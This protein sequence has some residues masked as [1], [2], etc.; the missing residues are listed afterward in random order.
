M[1]SGI[2]TVCKRMLW[3]GLKCTMVCAHARMQEGEEQGEE[4]A[5]EKKASAGR[6]SCLEYMY[7]GMNMHRTSLL[8]FYSKGNWEP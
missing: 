5:K 4:L 7:H 2:K 1:Y 8:K 3:W 6:T